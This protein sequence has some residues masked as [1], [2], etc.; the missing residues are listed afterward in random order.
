M[1]KYQ[2]DIH[3]DFQER[4]CVLKSANYGKRLEGYLEFY[5]HCFKEGDLIWSQ[6]HILDDN[7]SKM[8]IVSQVFDN[9]VIVKKLEDEEFTGSD[10]D[11]YLDGDIFYSTASYYEVED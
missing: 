1:K 8:M 4:P 6:K 3:K 5:N 7:R 2:L 11:D 10:F 9:S